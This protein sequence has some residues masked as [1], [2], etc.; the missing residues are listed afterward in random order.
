MSFLATVLR[1]LGISS[2]ASNVS[3]G[4]HLSRN[5]NRQIP[6]NPGAFLICVRLPTYLLLALVAAGAYQWV[7]AP[8]EEGS[9]VECCGLAAA[10]LSLQAAR[11]RVEAL[12]LTGPQFLTATCTHSF[13]PTSTP[14][15]SP[16][17]R[18]Q[19]GQRSWVRTINLPGRS[20]TTHF[21]P[22]QQYRPSSNRLPHPTGQP[23]PPR[24]GSLAQGPYPRHCHQRIRPRR[25]IELV[26]PSSVSCV[27]P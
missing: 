8:A 15:S 14:A 23:P 16:L 10:G 27:G 19:L 25:S 3:I 20:S 13:K 6:G 1:S 26:E 9:T 11:V 17:A 21:R 7:L 4:K 12:K 5:G 24:Q 18:R 22:Q 2:T